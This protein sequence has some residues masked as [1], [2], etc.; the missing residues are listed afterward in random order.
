MSLSYYIRLISSAH[1]LLFMPSRDE[2]DL[3]GYDLSPRQEELLTLESI[4]GD[5]INIDHDKN[6]GVMTIPLETDRSLLVNLQDPSGEKT[7]QSKRIKHLPPLKLR[8]QLPETYPFDVAPKLIIECRVIN[9]DQLQEMRREIEQQWALTKD[10]VLFTVID[11][12]QESVNANFDLLVGSSVHCGSDALFYEQLI[13]HD[14]Q[15]NQKK[16]NDT[17]FTC[18]ICQADVKG[19]ACLQFS[20]CGHTFCNG[21]LRDFFVSLIKGGDVEKVHCPDFNCSKNFLETRERYLRLDTLTDASFDFDHF[22]KRLMTPFIKLS[23]V[24]EIL[25]YDKEGME[26]YERF[27]TLFR[28]H[29]HTLIAKMFPTRLVSC[30]RSK[31]PAMIFREDMTSR[32]VI[33]R[34]CNY[35]FCNTCRKSYHSDSIDCAKVNDGKQYQGVPIEALETWLES[36]PKSKERNDIRCRYGFDLM[37]KVSQE[38][39]MD[40]LFSELLADESQG[41]RKC[42]TCDLIIQRSD[43]CNKMRCSSCYT[44]FCNICGVY[45]E[46]NSPYDHFKDISSPCFGKLFEGMPGMENIY[47]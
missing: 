8:F 45:L 31:C 10:Q 29:Q 17:T 20:L 47:D 6:S 43:G 44:F 23:L 5:Q 25:G 39:K 36:D 22:R 11:I 16:F 30:P 2:M 3:E 19:E 28:D 46:P 33:C 40:K 9:E 34:D 26:L 4:Y 7:I 41:F 14:N 42:P 32:L 18:E 37:T 24:H 1:I 38:Y 12:L 27:I 21:C 35:A 13:E 15:C